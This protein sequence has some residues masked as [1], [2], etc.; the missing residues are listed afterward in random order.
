MGNATII[1]DADVSPGMAPTNIPTMLPSTIYGR[2]F[3]LNTKG[4]ASSG[5]ITSISNLFPAK[6]G[7]FAS[8]KAT[9]ISLI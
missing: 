6:K 3:R 1:P 8:A 5:L 7:Y 4:S 9:S 2:N